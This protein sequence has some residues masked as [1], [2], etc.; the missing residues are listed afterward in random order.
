MGIR[1]LREEREQQPESQILQTLAISKIPAERE[2]V[3]NTNGQRRELLSTQSRYARGKTTLSLDLQTQ[4]KRA[5]NFCKPRSCGGI[6]TRDGRKFRKKYLEFVEPPEAVVAQKTGLFRPGLISYCLG[7]A[8]SF[9]CARA[10]TRLRHQVTTLG[11]NSSGS[12]ASLLP[13]M[14]Q[15]VLLSL[16]SLFFQ[17]CAQR[18]S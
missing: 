2:C 18:I 17:H 3:T 1:G 16:H 4:V 7:S 8:P 15:A 5:Y 10:V 11:T 12:Q 13:R 6:A 14:L 9:P